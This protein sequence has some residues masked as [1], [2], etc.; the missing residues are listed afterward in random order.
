MPTTPRTRLALTLLLG[1]FVALAPSAPAAPSAHASLKAAP[2]DPLTVSLNLGSA[3]PYLDAGDP[4]W[5]SYQDV[6]LNNQLFLGLV[7]VDDET[8]ELTGQLA[9]SWTANVDATQFTFTLRSDATWTDGSPVTAA[10]V[11]YAILRNLDPATASGFAYVLYVIQNAYE[12]NNGDITNPD[13]VGV[14]ALD[15]THLQFD[16]ITSAAYFPSILSMPVARSLPQAIITAHPTDWTEPANIITNGAYKLTSWDH[17]NSMVLDKNMDYYDANSVQIE[18]IHFDMVDEAT[19]W[20]MYSTWALDSAA[21]PVSEWATAQ[22]DPILQAQLHSASQ[23]CTYYYGFNT[24]KA[25]FDDP[26]VRKAFVAAIDRQGLIDDV[27]GGV[28]TP[29]QTFTSLG[30][31]GHIDGVNEGV[32]IPYDPTQAQQWLSDAGYPGGAGLPSIGLGIN[33]S[34]VHQAIADHIKQDWIDNLGVT[35]TV[36]SYDW[37]TYLDLLDTDAPQI[38]RL[39]WCMDFPDAHNYLNDSILDNINSFGGWSDTSYDSLLNQSH[40]EVDPTTRLGLYHQ[41]ETILVETDAIMAPIYFYATGLVSKQ[42][43]TR[44]YGNNGYS[45]Y[46]ADWRIAAFPDVPTSHWAFDFVRAI[47]EDGLTAGYPDGTFRPTN[48][49]NRAEMSVFLEKGVHG[50]VY[51]PPAPDGSSPFSDISGHWAEAWI[52]QLYD[53]GM[54]GGYPDGTY[55]PANNVSRA[56]MAVFLLKGEHG[57]SYLP[58]SSDGSSP[59]TDIGGSWALPWIEQLYD[60]GITAGYP[61]GTYRPNNAVTRAEMAVFLVNAFSL[62]MP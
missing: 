17:G 58:P 1:T 27:L 47:K 48:T 34:T 51:T 62:P 26:L 30:V 32:G 50:A 5:G 7:A 8:G 42:T 36:T 9:T 11:R 41:L 59:F 55:R 18:R 6:F 37:T 22:S 56:E 20:N 49:V 46:V 24:S 25:P 57:S 39:G 2:G 61:D 45:G 60:E 4:N 16:L 14:T 21:V 43:L 15:S 12:F 44:T 38:W 33:D 10:D 19:G 3:D 35:V 52:E 28:Q 23:P 54:T 29:A 53:D 40:T 31:Y 13:L